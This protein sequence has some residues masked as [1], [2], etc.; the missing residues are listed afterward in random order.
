MFFINLRKHLWNLN[1]F[2]GNNFSQLC[3]FISFDAFCANE[4]IYSLTLLLTTTKNYIISLKKKSAKALPAII[5]KYLGKLT[6]RTLI[7]W[8][9]VLVCFF[10]FS[11]C[12]CLYFLW[13][14]L[15]AHFTS[16]FPVTSTFRKCRRLFHHHPNQVFVTLDTH[17]HTPP[18]GYST[19]EPH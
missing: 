16:H 14:L 13:K 4:L 6:Q 5:E 1:S 11:F 2:C 17:K 3:S 7:F 18:T 15:Q 10:F 12:N 19:L 9:L 8:F